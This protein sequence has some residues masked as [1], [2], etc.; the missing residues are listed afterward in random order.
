MGISLIRDNYKI[1]TIYGSWTLFA[2]G[3][4]N[5]LKDAGLFQMVRTHGKW[6]CGNIAS[7]CADEF[8]TVLFAAI[9][10]YNGAQG[11][12]LQLCCLN[13]HFGSICLSS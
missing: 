9:S 6:G 12:K 7:P 3:W 2:T 10:T 1:D 13:R 8:C 11:E 4:R 5:H